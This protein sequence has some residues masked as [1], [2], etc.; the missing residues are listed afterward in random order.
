MA[1][2]VKGGVLADAWFILISQAFVTPLM[3]LLDV[4]GFIRLIRRKMIRSKYRSGL[5]VF[6]TQ[7]QLQEI[8]E[9]SEF[10]P[11]DVYATFCTL[12]LS[13]FFYQ[14]ILPMSFPLAIVGLFMTFVFVKIKL[15][16]L[17]KISAT[18]GEALITSAIFGL[19]IAPLAYGVDLILTIRWE[20]IC[21][22]RCLWTLSISRS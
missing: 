8:F 1:I 10:D 9:L 18:V 17:S 20:P 13:A 12:I 14:S 21:S 5:P 4:G 16:Y 7:K 19:N 2:W 3:N 6:K 11:S 22:R 15:V